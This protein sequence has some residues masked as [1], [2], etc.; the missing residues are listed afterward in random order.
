MRETDKRIREK[1]GKKDEGKDEEKGGRGKE[2]GGR[3]M[4]Y[5]CKSLR[6]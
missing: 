6:M 3:K 2:G 1:G 5:V 4:Y